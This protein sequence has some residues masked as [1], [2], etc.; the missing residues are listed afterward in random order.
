MKCKKL[1]N[2]FL[3]T[4]LFFPLM[5][6]LL[7]KLRP[8]KFSEKKKF[9]LLLGGGLIDK[10]TTLIIEIL[11]ETVF[12][13]RHKK[14]K[15]F[16]PV[17]VNDSNGAML[18]SLNTCNTLPNHKT[19]LWY[20]FYFICLKNSLQIHYRLPAIIAAMWSRECKYIISID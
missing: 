2:F 10:L 1:L 4:N 5:K 7:R 8:W 16:L 9:P 18:R 14:P 17:S 3:K 12:V 20:F 15:I 19:H 6:K 13:A 11:R